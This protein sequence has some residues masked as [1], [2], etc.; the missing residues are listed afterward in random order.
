VTQA[1]R[2]F[3]YG[4]F[5]MFLTPLFVMIAEGTR[6]EPHLVF[7]R[8]INTALGGALAFGV[9]ALLWPDWEGE[10]LNDVLATAVDAARS[11]VRAVLT[12]ADSTEPRREA[13][14][15]NANAE[16]VVQRVLSDGRQADAVATS[17]LAMTTFL[18]RI[19][20]T[21]SALE[22]LRDTTNVM[23]F[24]DAADNALAALSRALR[25]GEAPGPAPDLALTLPKDVQSPAVSEL[26]GYLARQIEVLYANAKIARP[27][28]PGAHRA[29]PAPA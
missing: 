15:A 10:T 28:A 22:S 8:L 21:T 5:T 2:P 26:L 3:G 16:V 19:Y 20:R 24:A 14:L 4:Y 18:R 9:G 17:G 13:G 27:T 25:A 7:A 6:N 12:A 11:Y 1:V 23:A 29:E